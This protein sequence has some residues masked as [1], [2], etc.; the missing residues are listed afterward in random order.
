MKVKYLIVSF[1]LISSF[2]SAQYKITMEDIWGGKFGEESVDEIHSMNNGEH[3]TVLEYG[4]NG[5]SIGKYSYSS[6]KKVST[7]VDGADLSE[8]PFFTAYKFSPNEKEVLLATEVSPIYRH[9]YTAK[10]YLY[11]LESKNLKEISGDVEQEP[12]FSPD[13]EKVAYVR[14]NNIYIKNLRNN[15]EIQVTSDGKKNEI[16]N[17]VTDWVYE[18]E[19]A[20]VRAFEWSPGGKYI[21]YLKFDET[22]VPEISMKVFG[23]NLYCEK[24]EFKYPKAGEENSKVSL[25]IYSV[26]DRK[27]KEVSVSVEGDYYIPKIKWTSQDHLL[28]FILLNRHQ[29]DLKLNL[30]DT[31]GMGVKTIL[32]ETSD[33]YID[34]SDDLTFLKDNSFLW[35]S[36]LN[37]FNHIYH[38]D[39]AGKLI[40]QV[41]NGPW[42]VSKFYGYNEKDKRLF[43]QSTEKSSIN[44][45]VYSIKIKGNHKRELSVDDGYND[46]NFSKKFKYYINT[47]SAANTP[48]QFTLNHSKNGKVIKVIQDNDSLKSTLSSYKMSE[49]KFLTIKSNDGT[50]LNAWMI[51]PY[52]FNPTE[53]YPVLM[54][55]YGGPGSQ[56]VLNKWGRENYMWFELLAQKGYIVVSVDNRGTGGKGSEFKKVTYKELG[57][58]EIEDQISA[59]EYLGS[60]P[61]IDK[62]R[63]GMFGWSYGGYMSSLA[64]TKG[65][66]IFKAGIAV[67]PVTNWRF[68]DSVYTERYMQLPEEN[69]DGYDNN[70]PINH[71]S[72]LKGSY[73]LIHGSS[74][75]NVHYQNT[76]RMVEALIEANK[77]FELFIYP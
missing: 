10:H 8:A 60:L 23:I 76:M 69:A 38:Y 18:E 30:V 49:K 57:K 39:P 11:N 17:G 77:Q 6:Y 3:Y 56:T 73:L 53:K 13:G 4:D 71:V 72:K 68:Y 61:Y 43:Y 64:M 55:V 22:E 36:E 16:I 58:I 20:F 52:N 21:A 27:S 66:D 47:F 15:I 24:M 37:G 40:N 29:N 19:F 51:K 75:D 45:G 25:H 32:N 34:M 62:D 46:A 74:D 1:L 33:T 48:R 2:V 14:D 26:D 67:A 63:I 12:V 59:A 70:S 41:T 44:R 50:E 5:T 65:A 7:I 42:E 28:S 31:Y 9:S 54:Y 35:T